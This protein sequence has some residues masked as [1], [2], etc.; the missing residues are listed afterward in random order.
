MNHMLSKRSVIWVYPPLS[1]HL[2][3]CSSRYPLANSY[4][5]IIHNSHIHPHFLFSH[6]PIPIKSSHHFHV[7]LFL[8]C[9]FPSGLTRAVQWAWLWSTGGYITE[10][11]N[12]FP[13]SHCISLNLLGF[14]L[15]DRVTLS[16]PDW[17]WSHSVAP[18][19]LEL[20]IFVPQP[21]MKPSFQACA[22]LSGLSPFCDWTEFF[23]SFIKMYPYFPLDFCI[24]PYLGRSPSY[25]GSAH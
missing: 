12:F 1:F 16:C 17:P 13:N 15:R 10:D 8:L 14:L 24:L 25:P 3:T 23:L 6:P 20:V 11:N 21:P 2:L 22:T 5:Y 18:A 19:S 7:F 4:M 9:D